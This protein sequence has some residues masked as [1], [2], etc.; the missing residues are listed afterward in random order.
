M[1][2]EYNKNKYIDTI[3]K[4]NKIKRLIWN[5]V[6]L[7][8]FRPTPRW[9]L[10]NWR[11]FLLKLFGAKIGKGS[12]IL[13]SCKIWAPWNL[14][15]GNQSI[16]GDYVDCYT[17]DKIKIGNH[18]SISQRSFLCTGTHD[19]STYLKPLITHPIIIED[20]VWICAESFISPN[21][22]IKKGAVTA[23]RSVVL[24]NVDEFNVVGGNPA[25]FIKIREIV[26]DI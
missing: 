13:P 17:M 16:L 11:I 10:N 3:P 18:V 8:L 2:N 25:K 23:A 20:H 9:A 21:T 4:S 1:M 24:K 5:T 22:I 19:I 26:K 6:W 12:R 7:F 14:D 15:M